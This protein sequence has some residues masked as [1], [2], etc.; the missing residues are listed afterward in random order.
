LDNLQLLCCSCHQAKTIELNRSRKRKPSPDQG[1]G[2][3]DGDKEEN[4]GDTLP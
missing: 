2:E 4:L 1:K 3:S